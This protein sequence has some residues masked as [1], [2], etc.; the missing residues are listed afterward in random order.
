MSQEED[1]SV[2]QVVAY[3]AQ[4]SSLIVA[5]VYAADLRG[6]PNFGENS[7]SQKFCKAFADKVM[8]TRDDEKLREEMG[9]TLMTIIRGRENRE[10]VTML[11]GLR[12]LQE[13]VRV[14]V[15]Y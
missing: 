3:E 7:L 6:D 11:T 8:E 13:I 10:V 2:P 12:K 4:V 1:G 9:S 15:V 14:K 5:L